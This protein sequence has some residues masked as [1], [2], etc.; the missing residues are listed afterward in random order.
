MIRVCSHRFVLGG[1]NDPL[2]IDPQADRPVG[3]GCRHAIAVRSKFTRHVG[4]TRLVCS[5]KPSK[6][7]PVPSGWRF[8][9]HAHQRQS[10]Q[11]TMLDLAQCS[12]HRSS[13]QAFRR[14]DQGSWVTAAKDG[15]LRLVRFSQ[16][17]L[18]PIPRPDCRTRVKQ[19]M[20]GHRRKA[21]I[22]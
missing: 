21:C 4:D 13:S 16:L 19:I 18:S 10:W 17:G 8:P 7:G 9:R 12:I 15:A 22:N 3:E 20:A 14:Q 5:T 6:G 11:D 1:D 2:R